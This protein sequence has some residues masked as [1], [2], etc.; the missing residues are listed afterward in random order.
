MCINFPHLLKI[1]N[2][3]E[4]FH[5]RDYI[6]KAFLYLEN[7]WEEKSPEKEDKL[8]DYTIQCET[9][10]AVRFSEFSVTFSSVKAFHYIKY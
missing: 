9:I 10:Y 8:F 3:V 4:I 2:S 5:T 6:F 1:N 7:N